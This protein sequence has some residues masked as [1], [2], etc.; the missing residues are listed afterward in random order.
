MEVHKANKNRPTETPAETPETL[1]PANETQDG[2]NY[3]EKGEVDAA[4]V[5]SKFS[6]QKE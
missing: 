1:L 3:S 6:G 4:S 2:G 5:F